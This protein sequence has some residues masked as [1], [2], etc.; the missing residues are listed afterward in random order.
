M[1]QWGSF[2]RSII[3][4]GLLGL[5]AAGSAGAEEAELVIVKYGKVSVTSPAPDAK[6]YVDDVYK[7]P[8]G[9]IIESIT[10]GEHAV[11]CRTETRAVSGVF[12]IKKDELLHLEAHFD[13]NKLIPLAE[14]GKVE[15]AETEKKPKL[16][17][18]KPD[19]PIKPVVEAKKEER[20]GPEEERRALH[21][22]MIK[23][24]FE[25]LKAQEARVSHK[26]NLRVISRYAE[27]KN[28]MGT[29]Y[30]T[31]QNLLLCDAGPCE[32][33]WSASFVYTDETGKS[34]TIS[35]TWKQTVFNGI[36]PAG[37]SKRELL[38]CLNGVC[39]N[40][41]EGPADK[42]LVDEAGRYHLT[43]TRSSLIIRRSDIMKEII[44][45]GG[46]LDA[47]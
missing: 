10:V 22:N 25:D 8:A 27:K 1:M 41:S 2:Q 3:L 32:Q 30:R 20:K 19:K 4:L 40:N 29:Y 38:Y 31:K 35:L 16:E 36:T 46:S 43:W 28:H 14:R 26:I 12:A 13:Q 24:F 9:S 5:G 37:T 42:P 11:S 7:G 18:P 34:D 23:V 21:L 44:D 15:K 33:Q 45:A 39:N 6:V 17:A 47:Y